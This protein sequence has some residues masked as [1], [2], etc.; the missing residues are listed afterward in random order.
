MGRLRGANDVTERGTACERAPRVGK[1]RMSVSGFLETCARRSVS[2]ETFG[3][4]FVAK[5]D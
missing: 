2:I 1:D 5:I 4:V 3:D